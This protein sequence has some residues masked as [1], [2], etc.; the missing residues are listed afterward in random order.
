MN[1]K[2][3]AIW[4]ISTSL[5]FSGCLWKKKI[6]TNIKENIENKNNEKVE[7]KEQTNIIKKESFE[8]K[9]LDIFSDINDND[10]DIYTES[11]DEDSSY[12][13]KSI[14]EDDDSEIN[15][16]IMNENLEKEESN[17]YINEKSFY[18]ENI[19]NEK[20]IN[21]KNEKQLIKIGTLYFDIDIFKT[22]SAGQDNA[23][24]LIIKSIND[25]LLKNNNDNLE[26]IIKGHACDSAG[27][28]S[29]NL[30]LSDKR[31]LSIKKKIMK[32]NIKNITI[33]SYGCGCTEKL[34]DGN[35]EEQSIN[36]RI[37]I[38]IVQ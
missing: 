6:D 26:I 15:Q 13:K 22:I 12:D 36:R 21:T 2:F 7:S 20:E 24:K 1:R 32:N 25:Y 3:L 33:S 34:V 37:E 10:L 5:F 9:T 8:N 16:L 28:E 19:S 14:F 38:F 30:H 4:L 27:S 29:Y 18:D 17:K 23:Y 31:A 35:R 11:I